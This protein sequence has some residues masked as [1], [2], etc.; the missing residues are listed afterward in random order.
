MQQCLVNNL[1]RGGPQQLLHAGSH[2]APQPGRAARRCGK[3][4]SGYRPLL[5][6]RPSWSGEGLRAR[7][8]QI[9]HRTKVG[10]VWR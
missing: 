2:G 4:I 8:E 1:A 5:A 6:L 9:P 3:E 10:A 7:V